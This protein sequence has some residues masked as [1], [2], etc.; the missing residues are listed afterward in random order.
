MRCLLGFLLLGLFVAFP[1]VAMADEH[2]KPAKVAIA[3]LVHEMD[4]VTEDEGTIEVRYFRVIEVSEKALDA[5]LAHGDSL[6][7]VGDRLRGDVFTDPEGHEDRFEDDM[8][9]DEEP[10]DDDDDEEPDDDD[11]DDD[12]D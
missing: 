4:I 11:D 1:A 6:D 9:D 8:D 2:A 3:H 5:H 7:L 10:D 12:D